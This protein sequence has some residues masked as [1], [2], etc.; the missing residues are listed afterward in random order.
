MVLGLMHIDTAKTQLKLA[1][2]LHEEAKCGEPP[3]SLDVCTRRQDYVIKAGFILAKL[4]PSI[5]MEMFPLVRADE[6]DK[7]A[8]HIRAELV[9]C[10]IFEKL[11]AM[12]LPD[13]IGDIRDLLRAAKG[14]NA[15]V[16]THGYHAMC[17]Y[18]GWAAQ[19]AA[20]GPKVD[21]RIPTYRCVQNGGVD[22]CKPLYFCP[23]S[24][25]MESPCHGGFDTCC[26]SPEYH[27]EKR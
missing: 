18:G 27:R 22:R 14:F 12:R 17:H 11:E 16:A 8:Y 26:A 15:Q 25:E 24:G 2:L 13:E 10:D 5:S 6:R 1:Q 7:I 3:Y 20:E 23:V 9:C 21:G 4:M 19:L